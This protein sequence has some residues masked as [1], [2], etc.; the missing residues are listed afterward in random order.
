M[1]RILIIEDDEAIAAI[2]R[3]YLEIDG[4]AVEIAPDGESG[5]ARGLTGQFDLILLD[6]MLPGLDG[7][8]V[9]RRLRNALDIP[10]LMVTA[11]QEDIDKIRGLG[12]GADDYIEKPFPPAC[13]SRASK[14]I[15]HG[16]RGSQTPRASGTRSR[17]A[18]CAWIPIRAASPQTDARAS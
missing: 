9:C 5:L 16:T 18:G 1:Q 6:L 7:F 2:E 15:S 4:F 17:S 14:R 10:I 8:A 11:R 3:D 13:L 12:L